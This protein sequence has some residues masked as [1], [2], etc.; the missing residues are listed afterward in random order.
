MDT[1]TFRQFID[2]AFYAIV[3][4]GI[5]FVVHFLGKVS[6]SINELYVKMGVIIEK[7]SDHDRRIENLE[8]GADK[9]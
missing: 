9:E 5:G 8:E 6:S 7:V 1:S 3:T 2:T 4:G